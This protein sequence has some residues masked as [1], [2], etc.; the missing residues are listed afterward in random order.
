[1]KMPQQLNLANPVCRDPSPWWRVTHFSWWHV[2]HISIMIIPILISPR[3]HV[4]RSG[5][6]QEDTWCASP[7]WTSSGRGTRHSQ[8]LH[9]D[10]RHITFGRPT[11]PIRICFVRIV[12]WSKQVLHVI[13]ISC[14]D[15]RSATYRVKWHEWN[16]GKSPPTISDNRDTSHDLCQLPVG[17]WWL[18]HHLEAS[19]Q[20]K[21]SPYH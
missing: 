10:D 5:F 3:G 18:C 20:T 19:W 11:Y 1:M 14:H 2:A 13:P 17:W 9:P 6:P 4:A 12:D 15:P 7:I 16:D 8:T 21:I